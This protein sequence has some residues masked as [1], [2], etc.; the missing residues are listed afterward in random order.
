[1]G[2]GDERDALKAVRP[3]ILLAPV[4]IQSAINCVPMLPTDALIKVGTHIKPV[5]LSC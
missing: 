4:C 3:S 1:M 5:V 2:A